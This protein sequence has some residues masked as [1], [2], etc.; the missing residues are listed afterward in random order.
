MT[1]GSGDGHIFFQGENIYD[2]DKALALASSEHAPTTADNTHLA[3][4]CVDITAPDGA[5]VDGVSG[6]DIVWDVHSLGAAR[7]EGI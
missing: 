3:N 4:V 5:V 7:A 2:M 6:P 1:V